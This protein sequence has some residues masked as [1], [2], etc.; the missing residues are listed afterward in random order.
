[1]VSLLEEA[2]YN[3][4]NALTN[5]GRYEEAVASY[6]KATAINPNHD[7]AWYNRGNTL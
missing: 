7:L 3:Y 6:D 1:M 4:G 2:W 5:L